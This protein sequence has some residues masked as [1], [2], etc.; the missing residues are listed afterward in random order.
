MIDTVIYKLP[1]GYTLSS[2]LNPVNLDSPFGSY[3]TNIEIS[4]NELIYI[5]RQI[6]LKGRFKAED[7]PALVD[8]NN[9][10]ATADMVKVVLKRE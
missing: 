8:Y 5:R 4:S 3:N 10:V 7:Y 2:T 6:I 9:K 1:A